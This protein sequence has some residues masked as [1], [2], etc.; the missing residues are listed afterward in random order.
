MVEE[1]TLAII[2][3]DATARGLTDQII[4]RYQ[5]RGFKIVATKTANL[6]KEQAEEFYA[7]HR[8]KDFY[9]SLTAFM[10]SGPC[11]AMVLEGEDV[12]AKNR[13]FMGAT[14]PAKAEPGTLRREFGSDVQHNVV[15]GSDGPETARFEI[16]FFFNSSEL[17]C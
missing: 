16:S 2:K 9:P 13:E 4:K 15:H 12:I 5:D 17:S 8:G 7:V 10:S 14:D 6:S 11:V 3:P 1:K